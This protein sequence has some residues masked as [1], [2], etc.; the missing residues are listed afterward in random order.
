M[1]RA[2]PNCDRQGNRSNAPTNR[3]VSDYR[4]GTPNPRKRAHCS[5]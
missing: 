2:R 1:N 4:S 3:L 5:A